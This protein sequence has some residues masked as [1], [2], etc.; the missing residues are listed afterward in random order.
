K[1][2]DRFQAA[3][4]VDELLTAELAHL[5]MPNGMQQ[6]QR[7]WQEPTSRKDKN[8]FWLGMAGI[9]LLLATIG[10]ASISSFFSASSKPDLPDV[11]A[12]PNQYGI[13]PTRQESNFFEAKAAFDLAY[14]TH[15]GEIAL[16]GDMAESIKAHQKALEL[17]FD[18][19]RSSYYLGC[20][21]A[22]ERK[23]ETAFEWLEKAID[24]GF[25]DYQTASSQNELSRLNLDP[26]FAAFLNRTKELDEKHAVADMTYFVKT[27]FDKA[28][29][30]YRAWLKECPLDEHAIMMLGASVLEQGKLDEAESWNEKT[31]HSVRF[32][33]FGVYNLGCIAAQRGDAGLAFNFLNYSCEIGFSDA[34]HLEN[35]HQLIPLRD[36]PRFAELL[37]KM[38]QN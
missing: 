6:P 19:A 35:D 8:P 37:K 14:Q 5:Q 36:D 26:R 32:A 24:A 4:E 2:E 11:V 28:E 25:H 34:D 31:R 20:A 7:D 9:L 10:Y 12:K 23:N 18:P 33:N 30:H 3:K 1:Q 16:R 22:F 17:G 13:V 15:L 29:Q 27:D 38:K 21:Y